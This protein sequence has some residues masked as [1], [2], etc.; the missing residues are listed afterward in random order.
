MT[1]TEKLEQ[2]VADLTQQ[3]ADMRALSE[4]ATREIERWKTAYNNECHTVRGLRQVLVGAQAAVEPLARTRDRL[5]ADVLRLEA[6]LEA[7]EQHVIILQQ[8][9]TLANQ[10]AA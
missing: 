4:T 1:D 10:P 8:Q 2:R 9:R 7:A 6:E 5:T 3:L